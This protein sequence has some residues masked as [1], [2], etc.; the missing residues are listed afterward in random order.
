MS[1]SAPSR[2]PG[3]RLLK[4][5]APALVIIASALYS[6]VSLSR[7]DA[8]TPTPS[9][10]N[11]AAEFVRSQSQD[12]DLIVFAPLWIDPV[13][14]H[15][16]GDRISVAMAASMD[17]AG[18]ATIWELSFGGHRSRHTGGLARAQS[19]AFGPLTVH[20]YRQTPALVSYDF[21]ASHKRA[22][23]SGPMHGRPNLGLQEVGFE[24][25]QCVKVVPRPDQSASLLFESVALGS[26][27]VGYVGLA[28]VFTRRD[29]REPGQLELF[30][31]GASV[32]TVVAGVDDGW[33]RF[34]V[35]TTRGQGSV[36][37]R[38][39]ALGPGARDRRICFAAEARH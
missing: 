39:T 7:A 26:K 9:D 29:V 28:D 36:E 35:E 32:A 6:L 3:W 24:P 17:A 18:Y 37:F 38:L 23:V 13:G 10:W 25:H 20:Q 34:E 31:N 11:R 21:T 4:G 14:R 30:V 5:L 16:L 12:G 15:Y 27:I 2:R 22:K 19:Q 1:S 8:E 33:R